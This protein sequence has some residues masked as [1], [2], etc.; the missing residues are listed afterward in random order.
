[1][2]LSYR[3]YQIIKQGNTAIDETRGN[4]EEDKNIMRWDVKGWVKLLMN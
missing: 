2:Q 1:M 4:G 3:S